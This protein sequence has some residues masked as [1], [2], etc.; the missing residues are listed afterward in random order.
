[1]PATEGDQL[2][3]DA[4]VH[5]PTQRLAGAQGLHPGARHLQPEPAGGA[6]DRLDLVHQQL[7]GVDHPIASKIE[8]RKEGKLGR[9]YYPAAFMTNDNL[10][11]YEDAYEIGYEKVID[12]Y[13]AAAQARRP[14]PLAH[15]V[16][17]GHRDDPRHQQGPDLRVEGDQDHLLHPAPPAVPSR[18]RSSTCASAA[19]CDRAG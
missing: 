12:T 9:V 6:A 16:L 2:F 5:I 3:A 7:D 4:G 13:A 10:E 17:Q 14:G 19:R 15:A 18:A 1:M 8:I 11:Y